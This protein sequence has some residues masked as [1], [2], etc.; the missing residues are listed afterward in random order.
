MRIPL[1]WLQEWVELDKPAT[2]VADRL[3]MVGL[4]VEEIE[5]VPLSAGTE[6]VLHAKVTA[7]R[8]DLL[9]I[10][11]VAREAS[12]I[13]EVPLTLPTLVPP[14][15]GS[16]TVGALAQVELLASDLCPRYS[17]LVV[18]GIRVSE[19]PGWLK[20]RIV[21]AGMRPVSN[22]VDITNYVLMELGQPLHAFDLHLLAGGKII[23]RRALPQEKLVTIDETE[24]TLTPHD[25]VIADAHGPVALAG[26]MG[27]LGSEVTGA[28]TAV[29]IESAHFSPP[30]VRASSRRHGLASESS[31]RFERGVD[32]SG[33]VEAATR[34]AALMCQI[35]GGTA[36][37]GEIDAYPHPVKPVHIKFRPARARALLGAEIAD[38]EMRSIL[39]RLGLDVAGKRSWKVTAPTFRPDL[40]REEDLVEEVGRIW[41]YDRVP[42]TL[43]V[44]AQAR[45]GKVEQVGFTDE[46]R[47]IL[48]GLGLTEAITFSLVE[49]ADAGVYMVE[50]EAELGAAIRT[51]N[52]LAQEYSY[53]RRSLLPGLLRSAAHNVE[54]GSE[55]VFLFELGKIYLKDSDRPRERPRA[56]IILAGRNWHGGWNL[57]GGPAA[58]DFFALKGI[59]EQVVHAARAKEVQFEPWEHG[60]FTPAVCARAVVADRPVAWLGEAGEPMRRRFRLERPAFYAEIDLE[61]AQGVAAPEAQYEDISR[62]PPA[63]RDLA[64]QVP[65][66]LAHAELQGAI[67]AAAGPLLREI[68]LFDEYRGAPIPPGF[69]SLA[70]QLTFRALD[71][72]LTDEEVDAQVAKV[73]AR[74]EALPQVKVRRKAGTE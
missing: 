4:E 25:L 51:I 56:G 15:I 12:A 23:V 22:I 36:A 40:N 6:I 5:E 2:E 33:T 66:G 42:F 26:V 7:N 41:G 69:R 59:V 31:Y 72:T 17:A 61:A 57:A 13:F 49:E 48:L 9:S 54:H 45:G 37:Q 52:P 38:G 47:K 14:P 65:L 1:G 35:A 46:V 20:D 10:R 28:T 18:T 64:A 67:R 19:S 24:V 16:E 30:S 11:G 74:L 55:D 71:R 29:L 60:V 62:Y 70:Y 39:T 50:D 3:T 43:P 27:G 32:P 44:A 8:G 73:I 53:M 68:V 34:A 63:V 21:A 58:A